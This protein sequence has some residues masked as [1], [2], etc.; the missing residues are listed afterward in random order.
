MRILFI[1]RM[2]SIERGGGE[3]FDLEISRHVEVLGCEVSYLSGIPLFTGAKT[4]FEH[5]RSSTIRSPYFGW[6]PWDKVRG[7]WRLRAADFNLFQGAAVKWAAA[8]EDRFDVIQVCELP[9]FVFDWKRL[10]QKIPVVVRLTAP[11]FYDPKGGIPKAD[12][13]IASGTSL[14]ELH[15]RGFTS[16]I[17]IPNCVDTVLFH[18]HP[19]SFRARNGIADDEFVCVYVARFQA[20][21][22]HEML[23]RAFSLFAKHWP[24]SRLILAG[25]G[26]L[27]QMIRV[28]AR[29]LGVAEQII[30]LGEV[31]FQELP[32]V[33]AASDLFTISSDYESFCFAAL[34]A[35]ATSLP[36]VTTDIGWVPNLI[37]QGKGGIL[38]PKGDAN[39]MAGAMLDMARSPALRLKAGQ[40]NRAHVVANYGWN[41]SA[42]KLL[43][44]Y[45]RLTNA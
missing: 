24:K 16:V 7:G 23:V 12:A 37:Q 40:F 18:P 34:E 17:D 41:S 43:D 36:V 2:L 13:V 14:K 1:N 9:E 21:K 26:P 25:S 11:N 29:S 27:Q 45:R 38:V 8:N 30:F 20:F 31:K 39:A 3:T 22:N 5:P 33:Y 19:S 4:P 10:G 15:A 6:F 35:M 44:V 28:L 42:R 32:A